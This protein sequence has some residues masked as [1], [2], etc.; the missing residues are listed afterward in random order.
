MEQRKTLYTLKNIFFNRVSS[1]IISQSLGKIIK[2]G[3]ETNNWDIL[4]YLSDSPLLFDSSQR[5]A[6]LI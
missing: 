3:D 5:H 6:F 2:E 1:F 4:K